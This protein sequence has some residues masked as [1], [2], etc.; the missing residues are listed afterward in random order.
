MKEIKKNENVKAQESEVEEK[1][2]LVISHD[3]VGVTDD[4]SD[5]YSLSK[6]C[7]ENGERIT[8]VPGYKKDLLEKQHII[9]FID[10]V[11]NSYGQEHVIVPDKMGDYNL[12][13]RNNDVSKKTVLS[14]VN[15]EIK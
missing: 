6:K 9:M 2:M 4:F 7:C 5:V 14:L 1:A 10:A 3:V 8:I 11:C 13:D 15:E 12:L